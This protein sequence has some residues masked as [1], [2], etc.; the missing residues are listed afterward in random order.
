MFM[1]DFYELNDLIS[2]HI[3]DNINVI[4]KR[5]IKVLI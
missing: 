3:N 1:K 5:K 4:K 2:L